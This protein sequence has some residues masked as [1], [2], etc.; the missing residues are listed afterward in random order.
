MRLAG[1]RM[2]RQRGVIAAPTGLLAVLFITVTAPGL[3]HRT[4]SIGVERC[5]DCDKQYNRTVAGQM[6]SIQVTEDCHT[7]PESVK[8]QA[9]AG[10]LSK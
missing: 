6:D 7:L 10:A 3:V 1:N 9:L 2:N 5:A 8:N 4:S